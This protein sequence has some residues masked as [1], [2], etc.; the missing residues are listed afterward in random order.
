MILIRFQ[1]K[2]LAERRKLETKKDNVDPKKRKTNRFD[3]YVSLFIS[4][5]SHSVDILSFKHNWFS[6]FKNLSISL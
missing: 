4:L 5:M 1:C 2:C 3:E 6:N